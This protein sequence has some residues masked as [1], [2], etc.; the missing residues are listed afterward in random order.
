M[1][2]QTLLQAVL[3]QFDV[4][5]DDVEYFN[6]DPDGEVRTRGDIATT[7]H[8]FYPDIDV[9]VADRNEEC[10]PFGHCKVTREDFLSAQVKVSE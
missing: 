2:T 8:D 10:G 4:W 9:D 1:K 7:E 3:N 6:C 5:P